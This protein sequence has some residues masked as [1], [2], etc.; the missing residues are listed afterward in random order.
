MIRVGILTCSDKGST[1]ERID[2]SGP[3]I[4]RIVNKKL[5]GKVV[6]YEIVPDEKKV[7][8]S[9]LKQW[10]DKDKLDLIFTTG[11]TGLAKRDVT[12]EA[13]KG[14]IDYEIPG[15]GEIMRIQGYQKTPFAILS[16]ALAGLRK[17]TLIINLPGSE[18]AV[19]ENLDFIFPVLLHALE[20]IAGKT[21]HQ[22]SSKR[23]KNEKKKE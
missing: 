19:K 2:T 18:R 12:P 20:I 17:K 5:N 4:H 23:G 7:I 3:L 8:T 22:C 13:T 10:A 21:E 1:G 16:R 11:G 6:K 14:V 9:F 15:F